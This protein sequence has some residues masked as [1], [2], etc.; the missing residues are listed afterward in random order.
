MAREERS[1]Q[2]RGIEMTVRRERKEWQT[3]FT[4]EQ[5]EKG[6]GLY[7]DGRVTRFESEGNACEATVRIGGNSY[8][9]TIRAPRRLDE[10]WRSMPFTCTC[11]K[12]WKSR[13]VTF[14]RRRS[15]YDA[16]YF[17]ND[18]A[19]WEKCDHMVPVM[20]LWEE[21][22]G[23]WI[24]EET[25]EELEE[26]Y[27]R[28]E[29]ER[30]RRADEAKWQ[31]ERGRKLPVETVADW[32]LEGP[33]W[34][35]LQ[36]ALEG[37]QTNQY[38]AGHFQPQ[39]EQAE[40]SQKKLADGLYQLSCRE[41][42]FEDPEGEPTL[43]CQV[44]LTLEKDRILRSECTGKRCGK[45]NDM[46]HHQMMAWQRVLNRLRAHPV[47]DQT[48]RKARKLFAYF[49]EKQED[50]AEL[51]VTRR[52]REIVKAENIVLEPR[53][54][55][56]G[57]DLRL[58]Y[59][60]GRKA[61]RMYV[62][63]APEAL[64]SALDEGQ[65][66]ALG[67]SEELSFAESAFV[68]SCLEDVAQMR[69]LTEHRNYSD[70]NF[71]YEGNTFALRGAVLDTFYELHEGQTLELENRAFTGKRPV[72]FEHGELDVTIHS[73]ALR[74]IHGRFLGIRISG[75]ICM[76]YRGA[77][78][79]AYALQEGRFF[80][81]TEEERNTLEP[82]DR[83]SEDG[84][85]S[86]QIGLEGI[87]DF[88]RRVLPALLAFPGVRYEDSC[89][90]EVAA[91]LP[92]E[93]AFHFYLDIE[94]GL[95]ECRARVSYEEGE[96]LP[97]SGGRTAGKLLR[98]VSAEEHAEAVLLAVFSQWDPK[99]EVYTRQMEDESIFLFLH[100]GLPRL[101]ALGQV[102]ATPA[103]Q[104]LRMDRV[105]PVSMRVSVESGLLQLDIQTADL[106]R[107]ELLELLD[108]YEKK[109]TYHRLRS[110]VFIDLTEDEVLY[111][112]ESLFRQLRLA[113]DELLQ[114][115]ISLPIYR[116]LYLD[117]MLEERDA[118]RVSRDRQYRALLKN[119]ATIRDSDWEIPA[120]L[121]ETLRPYQQYG[122]K[123]LKTLNAAGFGGILADE[124]GL[125]KTVQAIALLQSEKEAG[126]QVRALIV[127]PA[128]LV[129]NWQE[130]IRRFAPALRTEVMGKGAAQRNAVLTRISSG[131]AA[132]DAP[133]VLLCSYELLRRD[134]ARY[135][136]VHFTTCILDEAQYIK[137]QSAAVSKAVRLIHADHRFALTGTPIENRLS[138]L[139][140]IFQF[141]MPG[142][143]YTQEEFR[144]NFE[145]PIMRRNDATVTQALRQ[146]TSPF[147]LRRLKTDVLRE[148][149]PKLEE[150]RYVNFDA[151]QRRIY[152]AQVTKMRE[153]LEKGIRGTDKMQIFAGLLRLR[154]ICCDPSLYLEGYSGS[155]AKREGCLELIR[156]AM[157]GG[158]RML[159]FSQFTSM[160]E[161]LERDLEK[162]KIPTLKL[163][164]ATPR[165]RR[166]G[167]V[168]E[169]NEGSIPVFL[170]SLKAGGT[171][172]NLTG[173]DLVIHYD[174]WWNLAAQNQATDR[175][176]R[177]GQT[178]QLTV[179]RL[180]TRG[181]IEERIL[182]LQNTKQDLADSVL[183]GDHASLMS[184]ST[185][186][187]LA[188]L[189]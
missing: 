29:Q 22:H 103:V 90:E 69:R 109:K 79:N 55:Q 106:S 114:K 179:Y 20:F 182:A 31:A 130:E 1:I 99:R 46:C 62:V 33:S 178:R 54:V 86:V 57:E 159:V 39:S 125:G 186:E 13:Y 25:E 78:G 42:F 124:M 16:P 117:R 174:P 34:F 171:G 155:S 38:F 7:I 23:P 40:I 98:D 134:I 11:Q 148:L 175:A 56:E 21:K 71:G 6:Y 32:S 170:I 94:N 35:D 162:E 119:F 19:L 122:F 169:F 47:S 9:I 172:L 96:E 48:D 113:P 10:S 123:W 185:E 89:R 110:G 58:G 183:S 144:E 181:T 184:L 45:E 60:V 111:E 101:E 72:R 180:I 67:K 83:I 28:I 8:Q 18:P 116:T 36:K 166:L 137:N 14:G 53:L 129:Y 97:L 139:W 115:Q 77:K 154:Q 153:L 4:K 74:D 61:G 127:C 161:L 188:L 37:A 104:K 26:K 68:S 131:Q 112:F 30:I 93:P 107:E 95:L 63:K 43:R 81:L 2:Y 82:F 141:L 51:S 27:Q 140:S 92:A 105:P 163:T 132:D 80:R 75:R 73:E 100:E 176:H 49:A 164:G 5:L 149:P 136:S 52:E 85:F 91:A 87:P 41:D 160:L 64:L 128:S 12:S 102:L 15:W 66:F 84:Q 65:S 156:S 147:I 17:E 187:L 70:R 44:S 88:Y 3:L 121:A 138:E 177:I 108:S 133:E 76:L 24:I 152:D 145:E 120:V 50:T 157:D 150:V 146:M 135:E 158:H 168:R 173:A 126:T 151:D 167:L 118:I 59:R 189:G 142:F 165:E 143:L